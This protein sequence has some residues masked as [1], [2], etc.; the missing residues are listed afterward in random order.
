[1]GDADERLSG[2]SAVRVGRLVDM[3]AGPLPGRASEISGI[4]TIFFASSNVQQFDDAA[5]VPLSA[6]AG[7]AATSITGRSTFF[8][9]STP[10]R[11]IV[12]YSGRVPR[13]SHD[14]SH[15]CRY[16]LHARVCRSVAILSGTSAHQSGSRLAQRWHRHP[17]Y[18]G[19]LRACDRPRRRC[20]CRHRPDSPAMCASMSATASAFCARRARH[21]VMPRSL[22]W[23][24]ARSGHRHLIV[25]FGARFAIVSAPKRRS[26]G[27]DAA[28]MASDQ[29]TYDYIVVGAGTAGCLLANRLSA[30][31][32]ARVLLLEAGGKD[33]YHWIHIPV[34]YL[35][36]MGN[37]RAD[38]GFK[39][40]EEPGLNGRSLNYPR[41]RVLGGCSSINGMIYMRGQ[42]RDYDL[43]RQM[44]CPGWA[45]DD[46][47][48]YFKK[49]E[50]QRALDPVRFRRP[51]RAGRRMA[52]RDG[53]HSVG[54]PRRLPRCRGAGRH[55]QGQRLQSRQQRRL[56]LF[57]RQSE[58]RHPLEHDQGVSAPRARPHEPRGRDAC[59]G[60][61]P[62]ARWAPRHRPDV[63]AGADKAQR[64][65]AA[66]SRAGRRRYRLA[67]DPSA[68]G[69]RSGRVAA[70]STASM[71]ATSCP[72]SARTCRTICRCAAPTRSAA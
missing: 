3:F 20:S 43:W 35:Y 58:I 22:S 67:A 10:D 30:D 14:A 47:L 69:H 53:A 31:R 37:P 71:F 40:A 54:H 33:N 70:A 45:W 60:R 52:H 6:S 41:G 9:A 68:V 24:A 65:C 49:H 25:Q 32:N 62:D 56:R 8:V 57:P 38:W 12:G 17:A 28:G 16:R 34:G 63:P 39:T 44:G 11:R 4:E 13:R 42:A 1:M 18:R 2:G 51:A 59:H 19:V 27:G 66:R 64:R 55:S 7:S 46:V 5:S 72:A 61:P 15:V 29:D 21:G 23:R 50:D 48:P 26:P 36:L